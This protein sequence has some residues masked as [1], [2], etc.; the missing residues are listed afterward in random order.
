MENG[1]HINYLAL[2]QNIL[3]KTLVFGS[4]PKD[5]TEKKP[6]L[7]H[8]GLKIYLNGKH[9]L[10]ELLDENFKLD[11]IFSLGDMI[12][13]NA[14]MGMP[15]SSGVI[16]Y[17]F[18][19]SKDFYVVIIKLKLDEA[20]NGKSDEA[21]DILSLI[22]ISEIPETFDYGSDNNYFLAKE[23]LLSHF[24]NLFEFYDSYDQIIEEGFQVNEELAIG[25]IVKYHFDLKK[26]V[27]D[28]EDELKRS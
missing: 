9:N 22:R 8:E 23:M 25:D 10:N 24:E 15:G 20:T 2:N 18:G 26:A 19:I 16:N 27:Q 3:G 5:G 17:E 6:I 1:T 4:G 12:H 11:E 28:M 21:V 13:P 14:M 7:S